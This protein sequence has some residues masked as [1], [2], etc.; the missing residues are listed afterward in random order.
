M[1]KGLTQVVTAMAAKGLEIATIA[2]MT[3]LSA[4][5]VRDLLAQ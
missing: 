1:T 5:T 3:G 2:E 4:A